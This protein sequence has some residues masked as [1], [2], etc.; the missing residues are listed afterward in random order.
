MNFLTHY[1]RFNLF[2]VIS[3]IGYFFI[4][5]NGH[6]LLAEKM[7]IVFGVLLIIDFI[8]FAVSSFIHQY[9]KHD[10]LSVSLGGMLLFYL[11]CLITQSAALR[12][13]LVFHKKWT[14]PNFLLII[15]L[16]LFFYLISLLVIREIKKN[17]AKT[18]PGN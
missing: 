11:V 9:D 6:L 7:L 17:H 2:L 1:G 10:P 8:I 13:W 12:N 18:T 14:E 5:K 4:L 15:F 16:W 3:G